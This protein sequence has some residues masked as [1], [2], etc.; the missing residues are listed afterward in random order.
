MGLGFE[1]VRAPACSDVDHPAVALQINLTGILFV[2]EGL[3]RWPVAFAMA[4]LPMD[5]AFLTWRFASSLKPGY[6]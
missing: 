1:D 3:R 5:S 6:L 4:L 2:F